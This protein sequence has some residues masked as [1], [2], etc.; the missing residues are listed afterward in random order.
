MKEAAH[1]L[2]RYLLSPLRREHMFYT[3]GYYI[4]LN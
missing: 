3:G 1:V 2:L 4:Y